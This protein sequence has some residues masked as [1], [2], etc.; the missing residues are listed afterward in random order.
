VR[1]ADA[2]ISAASDGWSW[3]RGGFAQEIL[4]RPAPVGT[5]LAMGPAYGAAAHG[6]ALVAASL[7]RGNAVIWLA[8]EERPFPPLRVAAHAA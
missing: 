7:V 4:S 8:A 5:V 3:R 2:A 6:L 1:W